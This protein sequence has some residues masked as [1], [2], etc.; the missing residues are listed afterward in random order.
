MTMLANNIEYQMILVISLSV[1][2]YTLLNLR[3]KFF[4]LKIL[5]LMGGAIFVALGANKNNPVFSMSKFLLAI[6]VCFTAGVGGL[7]RDELLPSISVWKVHLVSLI[8]AYCIINNTQFEAYYAILLVLPLVFV[9]YWLLIHRPLRYGEKVVLYCINISMLV[10]IEYYNLKR[11]V[12][13]DF[14]QDRP[15][16]LDVSFVVNLFFVT[17]IL[18]YIVIY[19]MNLLWI[20]PVP[21]KD[22]SNDEMNKRIRFQADLFEK[23]VRDKRISFNGAIGITFVL[24]CFLVFNSCYH[25]VPYDYITDLSLIVILSLWLHIKKF[26][27]YLK[28]HHYFYIFGK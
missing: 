26:F 16:Y 4:S 14:P 13:F 19:I 21:A 23:K 22:E 15:G 3:R 28:S 7:F 6:P 20:L 24:L 12:L 1:I 9:Y 27:H 11:M 8:Y 17:G 2:C 18:F 25:V 5:G 10:V